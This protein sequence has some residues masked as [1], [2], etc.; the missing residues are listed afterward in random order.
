M[1]DSKA[2]RRDR[3]ERPGRSAQKLAER[4]RRT[5]HGWRPQDMERLLLGYRLRKW[6]GGN[7]TIYEHPDYPDLTIS[8]LR[9]KSLR[10]WVVDDALQIIDELEQRRGGGKKPHE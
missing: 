8:V 7:H 5:K 2:N 4:M 10:S 9:H 6:E 3:E 1:C